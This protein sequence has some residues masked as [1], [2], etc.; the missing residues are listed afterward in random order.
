[1]LRLSSGGLAIDFPCHSPER[2]DW[3]SKSSTPLSGPPT[4]HVPLRGSSR[5]LTRRAGNSVSPHLLLA[6]SF[7]SYSNV[8]INDNA[9][10]PSSSTSSTSTSSSKIR[11][12]SG[13][14]GV[15]HGV[16]ALAGGGAALAGSAEGAAAA[17]PGGAVLGGG[18]VGGL[19]PARFGGPRDQ[20]AAAT[21]EVG[22]VA[23]WVVDGGGFGGLMVD[24]RLSGI[25]EVRWLGVL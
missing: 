8:A 1:M 22:G 24:G 10:S 16:A 4:A 18:G 21:C 5:L 13:R 9:I 12:R 23:H 7:S 14:R 11:I 15:R 2:L 20:V 3:T 17:G 25:L 6:V 19:G